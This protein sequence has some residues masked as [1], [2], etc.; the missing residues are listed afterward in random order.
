MR[1][2]GAELLDELQNVQ[3]DEKDALARSL[4]TI[5]STPRTPT[6]NA[7][8]LEKYDNF[9]QSLPAASPR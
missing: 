4:H 5:A 8:E 2:G 1:L 9:M 6:A 3:P 7:E